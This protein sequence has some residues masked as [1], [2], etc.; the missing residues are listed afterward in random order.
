[1]F[2]CVTTEDGHN[3][4]DIRINVFDDDD[5]MDIFDGGDARTHKA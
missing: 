4:N 3:T 2:Q 5:S 1:L